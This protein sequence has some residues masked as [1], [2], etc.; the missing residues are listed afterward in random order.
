MHFLEHAE[1]LGATP[2]AELYR[3]GRRYFLHFPLTG[4]VVE[5]SEE[6][7]EEWLQGLWDSEEE[8]W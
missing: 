4:E 6:E 8:G 1:L 3:R 2:E 7:A 5:V